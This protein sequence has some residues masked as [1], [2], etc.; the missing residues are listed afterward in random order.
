MKKML[1]SA[2]AMVA[3]T[4]SANAANEVVLTDTGC[5][6]IWDLTYRLN[7]SEN[8][9]V[10]DSKKEADNAQKNCED[11]SGVN[12]PVTGPKPNVISPR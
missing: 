5:D 6:L 3:F 11:G 2:I 10:E 12:G 7:R 4:V 1:F 8:K 9:S